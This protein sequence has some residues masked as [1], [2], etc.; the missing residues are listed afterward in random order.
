MFFRCSFVAGINKFLCFI[1]P[2][3]FVLNF[4]TQVSAKD[5]KHKA[6]NKS[7]VGKANQEYMAT[8]TLHCIS[9]NKGFV[10]I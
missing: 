9:L 5:V 8:L 10:T 1:H 2:N 7:T 4:G 6:T 3:H